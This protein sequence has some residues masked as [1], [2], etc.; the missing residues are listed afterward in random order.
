MKH[1]PQEH[2]IVPG[3]KIFGIGV[4][5]VIA[6]VI[7]LLVAYGLWRCDARVWPPPATEAVAPDISGMETPVFGAQAQ[8]L[9][10]NRRATQ[11]LR[12]YG[13][14]D[15]DRGIVRVPIE[16]AFQLYLQRARRPA[17]RPGGA[18]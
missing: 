5:T 8:G 10:L 4:G 6:T 16:V 3:A 7:G 17:A 11:H 13:W 1:P 15:R 14:V 18:P 9:D 12:T 2:D